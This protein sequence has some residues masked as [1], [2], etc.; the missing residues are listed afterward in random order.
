M[1]NGITWV[2]MDVHKKAVNV[3]VILPGRKECVE[4]QVINEPRAV[5]RLAK[6]LVRMAPGEVRVCYEAGPCGFVL[7]R[8][9]QA[10]APLVCEV[11]APSLIP[12]KPGERVKTDRKDARKLAQYLKSCLLTEVEP[13]SEEE[14]AVRDLSRCRE[15]TK[16][17]LTRC[18]HRVS[19]FLLRRNVHYRGPGRTWTRKHRTWL[20][21]LRFGISVDQ[22]VFEEYLQAVEHLEERIKGLDEKIEAI[23]KEE[24]YR[25]P[26]GRLR[27]FRGIDTITAMTV[28]AELYKFGR[29]DSPRQLM[30]YLGLVPSEYSSGDHYSRGSITKAG[31]SHVRR[32][33]VEAA[34]HYRHQPAVG[35]ALRKRREGQPDWVIGIADHAQQRLCRRYRRLTAKGK[36]KNKAVVAVARELAGFIW[37]VLFETRMRGGAMTEADQLSA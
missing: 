8:Q 6:K 5:K 15:K 24:P 10:A 23:A 30:G 25:E 13:P 3:A 34:W 9:L 27:C 18:R 4:W 26:V 11:V 22:M 21:G 14:E 1:S 31:N 16:Q 35:V 17:D 33:L 28:V 29:F 7:Q 32:V 19:R 36:P 20:R 37:S 12:T 2:G